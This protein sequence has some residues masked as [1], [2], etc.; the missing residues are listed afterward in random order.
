MSVPMTLVHTLWSDIYPQLMP[1]RS[2]R[3][4]CAFCYDLYFGDEASEV[5]LVAG[6]CNTI[7]AL[8]LQAA[9][10]CGEYGK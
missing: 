2:G 9:V 6:E 1:L 8:A 5:V 7:D 10:P 3:D 4:P